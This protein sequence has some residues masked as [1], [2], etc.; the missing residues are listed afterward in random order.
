MRFYYLIITLFLQTLNLIAQ[1]ADAVKLSSEQIA[2]IQSQGVTGIQSVFA[3]SGIEIQDL[4]SVE[5]FA[6]EVVS[7]QLS[8]SLS[9]ETI[10][11]I[12]SSLT[13]A[14]AEIAISEDINT[15]YVIEY[16]SA[17]TSQ[18]IVEACSK[19]NVDVFKSIT[20]A[21]TDVVT[22]AIQF[23]L[24]TG[25][26]IDKVVSAVGSGYLA[27]TIEAINNIEIDVVTAV[28]AC[29][30]GLIIGTINAT[31]DN[32]VEIYETL[33]STC[34]GIAEAAVEASVREQ[35][36]LI[37]QITAASVGAG[38]SAVETA[39]TLSLEI[40]LT[41]KAILKG[42]KRGTIDSIP[43]KGNNIRIRITPQKNI[44]VYEL[45]KATEKSIY[46][47]GLEAGYLPI[48][49]TPSLDDPTIRQV[50]PIN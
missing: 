48:I 47:S 2:T 10:T 26:D 37:K 28:K 16:V 38:T 40:S 24:E 9:T 15:S 12:A 22:S 46:S 27:G 42:L 49:E 35:L 23:S 33:A 4:P 5:A 7:S 3:Q 11:D 39:T 44:D 32:N 8:N 21:S 14:L 18:G 29:S 25:Y 34:E 17:G 36:D 1:P 31:L 13:I 19:N 43:G 45:L 50:S 41:Q 20:K 30:S 6:F